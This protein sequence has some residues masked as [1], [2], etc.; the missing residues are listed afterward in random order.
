MS[1][2]SLSKQIKELSEALERNTKI[3]ENVVQQVSGVGSDVKKIKADMVELQPVKEFVRTLNSVNKFLKWGG[4][5]VAGVVA[6]V[7]AMV[8]KS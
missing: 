3:T 5:T 7:Y 8:K 6:L 2:Q 1:E 4:L